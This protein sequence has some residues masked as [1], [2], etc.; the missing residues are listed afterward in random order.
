MYIWGVIGLNQRVVAALTEAQEFL[1]EQDAGVGIGG[2]IDL[3]GLGE[4]VG[5]PVAELGGFGDALAEDVGKQFLQTHVFNT[6]KFGHL[7]QVNATAR[8]EGAAAAQHH[9][10]VAQ[11]EAYLRDGRGV[12][13]EGRD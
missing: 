7:L 12:R 11:G 2:G 4:C 10:I 3:L 6:K 9:K 13:G 5:L 8:R 1:V